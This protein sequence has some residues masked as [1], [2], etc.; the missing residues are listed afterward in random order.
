M[1]QHPINLPTA[2]PAPLDLPVELADLRRDRPLTR[3]VFPDGHEG[4]LVTS[5]TGVRDVLADP[6]FSRRS[7]LLHRQIARP[8]KAT[9]PPPAPPGFFIGMDPPDH[10]RLRRHLTGQ[11]TVRRMNQLQHRIGEIA[12]DCLT[13]MVEHGPP[14]DL[15][16]A[17]ALPI[18]S[19]IICE[20]L[21][22]P[23][24]E[25]ERFQRDTA[26]LFSL[27]STKEEAAAA[28]ASLTGFILSLVPGKRDNPT[29]DMLSGLAANDALT[30]DEIAG[31]GMLL[32]F[33]GHET[34]AS[35]LGLGVYAL[36]RHPEQ[37]ARIQA[38]PGLV[39]NAVEELLRYL[40][41]VHL[42]TLRTALQDVEIDGHLIKKDECVSL[43]LP[44]ANHDPARFTDPERLDVGR[45]A[46]GHVGFGH[47]IHQCLGQQ[48][49]RIVLRVGYA[50]LLA[51]L[52][53]LR[54]AV[55]L[56]DVPMRDAMAIYGV[57][58]LPVTW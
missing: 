28:F 43:S 33:A 7:E 58:S 38:D 40:T 4:W 8:G 49:A 54:P 25:R 19:L 42:G 17:F 11:F 48:L 1:P 45:S 52:P 47:G 56:E 46:V 3:M 14:M 51:R 31:M 50:K 6:R 13:A 36:L 41:I 10:T 2:R 23:Y 20:L 27:E 57:H 22:V 39:D 24:T 37:L 53:G 15:V 30:D 44:A 9:T 55:P 18:P 16:E 12:D 21:G 5:Y 32:L 29:D 35:M 26:A 34:T